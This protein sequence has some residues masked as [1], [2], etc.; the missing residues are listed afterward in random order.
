[1]LHDAIALLDTLTPRPK[2][3]F[4][5]GSSLAVFYDHR[6]SYDVDIFL[7]GA[8]AVTAL[9][10]GRNRA[11]KALLA[12]RSFQFPGNYLKLEMDGGEIDFI[13]AGERTRD[14]VQPWEF[15]GR[16]IAIETLGKPQ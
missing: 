9:S 12:G 8:D 16:K 6:I 3:S 1:L 15:E 7:A 11:T 13:L 10:P 5:G 4:G 2:W 14:P